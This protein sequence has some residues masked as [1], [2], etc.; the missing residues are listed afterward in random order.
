MPFRSRL[1]TD[2][3][4]VYLSIQERK[5]NQSTPILILHQA[6]ITAT[7]DYGGHREAFKGPRMK[8]LRMKRTK[9]AL[10]AALNYL[11]SYLS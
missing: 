6:F 9:N 1:I 7:I 2:D 11:Y 8:A 10:N 3:W 4:I 5:A